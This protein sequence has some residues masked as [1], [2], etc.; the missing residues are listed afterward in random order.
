[1]ASMTQSCVRSVFCFFVILAILLLTEEEMWKQKTICKCQT[2]RSKINVP[3]ET[4]I[5][6]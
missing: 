3:G 1:M 2:A 6:K 5:F 4:H